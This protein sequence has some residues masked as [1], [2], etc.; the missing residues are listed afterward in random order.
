MLK[1]EEFRSRHPSK[2]EAQLI[3]ESMNSYYKAPLDLLKPVL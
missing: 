2:I 1:M 3:L